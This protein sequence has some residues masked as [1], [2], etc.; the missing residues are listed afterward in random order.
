MRIDWADVAF[1]GLLTLLWVGVFIV[2]QTEL[3][4]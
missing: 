1:W 3:R 4:L 2:A